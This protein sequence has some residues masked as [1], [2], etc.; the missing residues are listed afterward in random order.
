MIGTSEATES[1]HEQLREAIRSLVK[2]KLWVWNGPIV[3]VESNSMPEFWNKSTE[4]PVG[5][6][7]WRPQ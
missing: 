7:D 4:K 6:R 5:M 1:T 2:H 3:W